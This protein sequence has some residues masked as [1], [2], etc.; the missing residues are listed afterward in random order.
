[1]AAAMFQISSRETND[2]DHFQTGIRPYA[3]GLNH[4][5]K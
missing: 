2:L 5:A 4:S 1:M 3:G